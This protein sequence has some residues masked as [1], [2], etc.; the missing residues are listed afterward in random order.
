MNCSLQL[1]FAYLNNPFIADPTKDDFSISLS[2][3][4]AHGAIK[5]IFGDG[6]SSII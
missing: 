1:L 6:I 4:T 2:L 3:R 5:D